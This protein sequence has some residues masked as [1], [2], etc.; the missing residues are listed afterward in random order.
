MVEKLFRYIEGFLK[1]EISGKSVERFINICRNQNIRIWN[2]TISESCCNA[3]IRLSDFRKLKPILRKSNT[4][5]RIKE[6]RGFP[7]FLFLYKKRKIFFMAMVCSVAVIFSLTHFIW[8]I[9]ITG[10]SYYTDEI[11]EEYL[12]VKHATLG[13]RKKKIN[14]EKLRSD[15]R[16]DFPDITWVS[17]YIRGT[18]LIIEVKE[19]N[20]NLSEKTS[21]ETGATDLIADYSGEIYSIVTRKGIPQVHYGSK[22]EKGDCLVKGLL[23]ITDDSGE[24]IA[25]EPVTA[26]AEIQIKRTIHYQKSISFKESTFKR[27]GNKKFYPYYITEK[28]Y[29]FL[30][31]EKDFTGDSVADLIQFSLNIPRIPIKKIGIIQCEEIKKSLQ[32]RN[33]KDCKKLLNTEFSLFYKNLGKKR[34]Q[35]SKNDVKIYK[36][37]N[38]LTAKGELEVVH[39]VGISS[40][41]V[42]PQDKNIMQ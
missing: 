15:I 41:S 6:R 12:Y 3:Y 21:D 9:E 2:I 1:I 23:P 37:E 33:D 29:R 30:K 5:V 16:E 18:G 36:G 32:I 31:S 39:P 26:D 13:T 28:N 38:G 19:E 14:T 20:H 4:K 34:V 25:Y 17:V 40:P 7:F 22:V 42:I 27:T 8:K 24:T 10:N 11:L 35:I